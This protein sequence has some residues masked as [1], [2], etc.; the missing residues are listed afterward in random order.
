MINPVTNEKKIKLL[1]KSFYINLTIETLLCSPSI[2][3]HSNKNYPLI[4]A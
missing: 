1:D 2:N 3:L 4:L